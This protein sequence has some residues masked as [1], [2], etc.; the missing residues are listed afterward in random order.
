MSSR[1]P[2][3]LAALSSRIGAPAP[4][5][6]AGSARPMAALD[7]ARRGVDRRR[8]CQRATHATATR[9]AMMKAA[10]RSAGVPMTSRG[11]PPTT[12]SA[13]RMPIGGGMFIA[14]EG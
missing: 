4:G 2:G 7:P 8:R 10:A 6:R 12:P 5:W 9:T 3:Q 13:G 1:A 11:D 14:P